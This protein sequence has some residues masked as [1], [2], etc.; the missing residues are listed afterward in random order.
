[1]S[2]NITIYRKRHIPDEIVKLDK[3]TIL[4]KDDM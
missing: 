4:Y 3:D 1:M 2:D